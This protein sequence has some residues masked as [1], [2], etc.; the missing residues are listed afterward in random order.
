[1]NISQLIPWNRNRSGALVRR[2][3]DPFF[4]LQR[5]VN[6]LFDDMWRDFDAPFAR[7]GAMAHGWPAV[8]LVETDKQLTLAV[9]VPG[10]SEKDIEVQF[11]DNS[12]VVSGE[13]RVEH[14]DG[15]RMS[16]RYY[17]RFERR[18]PLNVEIDPDQAKGEVRNGVLTITLP[19]TAQSQARNIPVSRAA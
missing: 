3:S 16:E 4:S 5:D 2:E 13:R 17:G 1:M 19:K 6:R 10:M 8:D 9:E 11:V 12:I 15:K 18:I 7:Q 14:E